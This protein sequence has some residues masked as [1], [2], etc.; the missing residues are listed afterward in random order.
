[1]KP[2]VEFQGVS[3]RRAK[4]PLTS[5][6]DEIEHTLHR[7]RWANK[8]KVVHLELATSISMPSPQAESAEGKK[9]QLTVTMPSKVTPKL[10]SSNRKSEEKL[11][12]KTVPRKDK[13]QPAI[14]TIF[15]HVTKTRG[16]EN[17]TISKL[18]GST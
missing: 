9:K 3:T 2:T 7:G 1:M 15:E 14:N 18:N 16:N 4:V 6:V 8:S 10:G 17:A 11:T 12:S 13:L 5:P